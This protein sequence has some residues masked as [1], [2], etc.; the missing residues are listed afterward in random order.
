MLKRI[1]LFLIVIMAPEYL[2][3]QVVDSVKNKTS[4]QDVVVDQQD[5]KTTD[6]VVE[7]DATTETVSEDVIISE[8]AVEEGVPV[9][10]SPQEIIELETK[11]KKTIRRNLKNRDVTERENIVGIFTWQEKSLKIR[12]LMREGKSYNEA[13]KIV[14]DTIKVPSI[15][16]KNDKEMEEYMYKKGNFTSNGK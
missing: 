7:A 16:I 11:S 4:A 10:V 12:E 2:S 13:K 5:V 6:A 8:E 3:A 15:N 9:R 14:E 1:I